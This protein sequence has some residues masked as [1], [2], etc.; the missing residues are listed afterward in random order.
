MKSIDKEKDMRNVFI[1]VVLC[2]IC[3]LLFGTEPGY[4]LFRDD[5]DPQQMRSRVMIQREKDKNKKL[6]DVSQAAAA[7]KTNSK[8]AETSAGIP[9]SGAKST[10]VNPAAQPQANSAQQEYKLLPRTVRPA[11]D[12][13][14]KR[15]TA[16]AVKEEKQKKRLPWKLFLFAII[17]WVAFRYYKKQNQ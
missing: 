12:S 2:G 9:S 3:L 13:P 8:A 15:Q 14:V 10:A 6:Q 7:G 1:N 17:A 11:A 4:C 16:T 5:V